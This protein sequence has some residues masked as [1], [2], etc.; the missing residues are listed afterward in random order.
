ML[1]LNGLLL[2]QMKKNPNNTTKNANYKPK[3][4][5][6]LYVLIGIALVLV[7]TFLANDIPARM[8]YTETYNEL[9]KFKEGI[10]KQTDFVDQPGG[11]RR[12]DGILSMLSCLPDV[13]CPTVSGGGFVAVEKGK[14]RDFIKDLLIHAGYSS[15]ISGKNPCSLDETSVCSISGFKKHTML[16]IQIYPA[17]TV[18]SQKEISPKIWREIGIRIAE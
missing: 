17:K 16:G 1:N 14:E 12:G 11:E 7:G 2:L 13:S 4:R 8:R 3:K 9:F 15:S 6:G 10:A 18:P 5:R